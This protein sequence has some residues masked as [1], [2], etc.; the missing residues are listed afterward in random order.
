MHSRHHAAVNESENVGED[1][2]NFYL[3]FC[4]EKKH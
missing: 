1:T 3:V 2:K 4:N